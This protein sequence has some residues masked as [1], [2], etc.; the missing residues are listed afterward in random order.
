MLDRI[1]AALGLYDVT[2]KA[3][4]K[5]KGYG[6]CVGLNA[7]DPKH[8]AGWSGPLNACE[9]D[10]RHMS[11]MLEQK[12]FE[13]TQLL[14][15]NATRGNVFAELGSMSAAAKSG[16]IVVVTNSSHGSQITDYDGNEADSMDETICMFDGEILDD[17]LELAWSMFAPGVRIIFVSDSCHSGTMARVFGATAVT[18]VPGSRAVP[19]EIAASTERQNR[20]MYRTIAASTAAM[21]GSTPIAAHVL[22]LGACQDNQTAMDGSINGAFTGALLNALR[23]YPKDSMGRIYARVQRALPPTQAPKY[24]YAGPRLDSFEKSVAFSL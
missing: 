23:D 9:N 13:T 2:P 6:L 5:P 17:E 15:R 3:T 18:V 4:R 8:Y 21:R 20:D 16:D 24:V 1:L 10:A 22:A 11:H 19:P 12:G 14:T 7:V